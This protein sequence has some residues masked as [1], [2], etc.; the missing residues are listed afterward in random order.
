LPSHRN[1]KLGTKERKIFLINYR[2][3]LDEHFAEEDATGFHCMVCRENLTEKLKNCAKT[4]IWTGNAW[5]SLFCSPICPFGTGIISW[6]PIRKPGGQTFLLS[7]T[8]CL[9][10]QHIL[11]NYSLH[12]AHLCIT[13]LSTASPNIIYVIPI[14]IDGR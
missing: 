3:N 12:G 8:I 10:Q 5:M 4:Y 6:T 7:S 2:K 11:G 13:E 1:K 9:L 14:N